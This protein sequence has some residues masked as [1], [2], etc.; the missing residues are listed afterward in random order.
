MIIA[1]S[2]APSVL[3]AALLAIPLLVLTG[4]VLRVVA[5]ALDS[6]TGGGSE[7]GRADVTVPDAATT[8][9]GTTDADADWWDELDR[10]PASRGRRAR[11]ETSWDGRDLSPFMRP[12][13]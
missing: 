8:P 1:V 12:G 7:V 3:T 9:A 10:E 6:R 11:R 5:Q 4:T 13:D 2:V